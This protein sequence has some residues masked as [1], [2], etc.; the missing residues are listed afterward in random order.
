MPNVDSVCSDF[1]WA[2]ILNDEI[3]ICI[4]STA[5]AQS[6]KAFVADGD[7]VLLRMALSVN[8]ICSSDSIRAIILNYEVS[9][10]MC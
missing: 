8:C 3:S 9:T 5:E 10:Q 4:C 1:P 2:M 7:P 6:W